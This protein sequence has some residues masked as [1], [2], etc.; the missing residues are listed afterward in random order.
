M[1]NFP[2]NQLIQLVFPFLEPPADEAA[3]NGENQAAKL[4]HK[5]YE[6]E[7]IKQDLFED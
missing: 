4:S 2:E 5:Y 3:E 1:D 7:Y 6:A